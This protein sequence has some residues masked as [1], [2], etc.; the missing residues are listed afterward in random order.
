MLNFVVRGHP[1]IHADYVQ[2][3]LLTY[4]LN[5]HN[6]GNLITIQRLVLKY[7]CMLIT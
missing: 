5:Y 3:Y 1:C 7:K 2:V 6:L 4:K